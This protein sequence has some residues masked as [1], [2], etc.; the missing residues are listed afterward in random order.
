MHSS[1]RRVLSLLTNDTTP[2]TPKDTKKRNQDSMGCRYLWQLLFEIRVKLAGDEVVAREVHV[3][4]A[5]AA[6]ARLRSLS[7][8]SQGLVESLQLAQHHPAEIAVG[9]G[10]RGDRPDVRNFPWMNFLQRNS[11][12][13]CRMKCYVNR[14][15]EVQGSYSNTVQRKADIGRRFPKQN[16][17]P[18]S[19]HI[20]KLFVQHP[21][22]RAH[23]DTYIYTQVG[24]KHVQHI[25]YSA[26]AHHS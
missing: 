20:N 13:T 4:I 19:Q 2:H 15:N 9:R 26:Q 24:G 12:S 18:D 8:C 25:P 22:V 6:A 11:N 1:V 17:S 7:L 14:T 23:E 5:H 3:A 16:P 21:S 10:V